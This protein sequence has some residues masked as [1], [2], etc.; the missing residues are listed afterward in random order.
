MRENATKQNERRGQCYRKYLNIAHLL[1][2]MGIWVGYK[3]AD[4]DLKIREKYK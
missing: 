3:V 1:N 4:R 2:K